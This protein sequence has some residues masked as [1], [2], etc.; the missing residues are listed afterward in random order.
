M[1]ARM[2]LLWR[3]LVDALPD[4]SNFILL[5]AGFVMSYPTLAER[6]ESHKTARYGL[7]FLCILVG[8]YGLTVSVNERR[9]TTDQLLALVRNTNTLVTNT[10]AAMTTL[11]V[12]Q[13]QFAQFQAQVSGIDA[14]LREVKGNSKLTAELT[15]QRDAAQERA[16]AVAKQILLTVVPEAAGQLEMKWYDWYSAGDKFASSNM[17]F[18]EKQQRRADLRKERS[19][20]MKSVIPTA[21]YLRRQLLE[22]LPDSARTEEDAEGAADFARAATGNDIGDSLKAGRYLRSLRDRVAA[23][24]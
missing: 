9:Q 11:S 22:L 24:K 6:I 14:E 20:E 16:K 18:A 7:G 2:P 3:W 19:L 5:L 8:G 1:L 10:N 21:D 12:L 15:T 4:I 23:Q 17:L 13:P